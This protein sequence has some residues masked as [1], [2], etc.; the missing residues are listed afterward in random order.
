M[1]SKS[2]S[3]Y[4][5]NYLVEK[6]LMQKSKIK[7]ED[8]QRNIVPIIECDVFISYSHE[9][10]EPASKLAY[11]LQK[12]ELSTFIDSVYWKSIDSALKIYDNLY[13]KKN[14]G[15]YDYEK[16]NKSTSTFHMI[17]ADSIIEVVKRSK[18]FIKLITSSYADKDNRT[19]SPWIYLENKIADSCQSERKP[20]IVHDSLGESVTF[21]T[22]N[23]G[24]FDVYGL[25]NLI[26]LLYEF[27]EGGE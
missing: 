3:D 9:D 18:V 21:K 27:F 2:T 15:C 26:D 4:D 25:Q 5:I 1:E 10:I 20:Y 7:M 22:S 16:R 14:N 12:C 24:F 11:S 13:C 17:L 8:L 19:V 6:Q 23:D